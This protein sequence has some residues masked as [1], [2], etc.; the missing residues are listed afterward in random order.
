MNYEVK[1]HS[2]AEKNLAKLPRELIEHILNKIDEVQ[3]E[4]FR[5]LEHFEGK[6]T[7]K[8]R[9]G[10]YRALVEVDFSNKKLY[11]Q[12]FDKRSRVYKR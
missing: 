6:D 8:L 11:I 7:Y 2:K 5:F 9:L 10:D 4:P 3:K 1:W 12:V